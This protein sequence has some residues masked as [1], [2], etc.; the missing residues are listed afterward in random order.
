MNESSRD[1]R[2]KQAYGIFIALN[3]SE[4]SQAFIIRA[5]AK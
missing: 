3:Y 5:D 1:I 2:D 4:V